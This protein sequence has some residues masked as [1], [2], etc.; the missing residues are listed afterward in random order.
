M[1]TSCQKARKND[2]IHRC[3][4]SNPGWYPLKLL[5]GIDKPGALEELRFIN[6]KINNKNSVQAFI[7]YPKSE[8]TILYE[9]R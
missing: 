1:L 8:P 7:S 4:C 9:D 2:L 6:T 3:K 5:N